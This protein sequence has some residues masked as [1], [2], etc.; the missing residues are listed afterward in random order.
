P[1]QEGR[2]AGRGHDGARR[3]RACDPGTR[4]MTS[5]WAL[6]VLGLSALVTP[7]W[8]ATRSVPPAV[9][10]MTP[11][12]RADGALPLPRIVVL[13]GVRDRPG[14]DATIAAQQDPRSPRFRRWLDP[15]EIADR[16]GARRDHYERARRWLVERGFTV[17]ADSPFRVAITVEGTAALAAHALPPP[18]PLFPRP[19]PPY[20]PPPA[21]PP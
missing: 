15:T 21:H 19:P 2:R 12:G 4:R 9:A 5:V 1:Q 16:F 17:V 20:P 14:L 18:L 6:L 10:T 11:V 8:G 3:A 7:A 13:L